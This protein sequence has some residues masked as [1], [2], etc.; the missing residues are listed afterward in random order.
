MIRKHFEF[1]ANIAVKQ[2]DGTS[3]ELFQFNSK[4]G[5][6]SISKQ[7]LMVFILFFDRIYPYIQIP[8]VL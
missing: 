4:Y 5:N 1:L 7:S 2:G 8:V 3:L 6:P